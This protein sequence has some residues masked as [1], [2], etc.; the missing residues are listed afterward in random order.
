MQK[1]TISVSTENIFPIIKQFLYSDHEIFLRELVSNAVDATS[2]AKTLA[3]R[4]EIKGELGDTTI[5]IS[6]DKD[7]KTL[8]ISDKGIGMSKEQQSKIFDR[9]Y[10]VQR[11]NRH[12]VNRLLYSEVWM[13]R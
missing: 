7:A 5:E 2:K 10:R 4:G 8:T 12:D 3:L 9:F 1:G 6:V 13:L 11:S